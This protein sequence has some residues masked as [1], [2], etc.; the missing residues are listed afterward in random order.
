MDDNFV[1]VEKAY[2]SK[3][4]HSKSKLE[5]I[6]DCLLEVY[7]PGYKRYNATELYTDYCEAE[8]SVKQSEPTCDTDWLIRTAPKIKINGEECNIETVLTQHK[9]E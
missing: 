6:L 5:T 1:T 8:I 9:G 2:F 4:V 3:L 7:I